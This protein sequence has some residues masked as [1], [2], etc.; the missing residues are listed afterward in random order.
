MQY[1]KVHDAKMYSINGVFDCSWGHT[2]RKRLPFPVYRV[3][4]ISVYF[5]GMNVQ[6]R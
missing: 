4:C 3:I 2:N 5:A 1:S 6:T